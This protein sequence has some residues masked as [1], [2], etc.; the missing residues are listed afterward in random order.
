M[1]NTN[2]SVQEVDPA[3]ASD[4][5]LREFHGLQ[6]A[7]LAEAR[8]HDTPIPLDVLSAAIKALPDFIEVAVFLARDAS[9]GAVGYA[10]LT[11]R[12][13]GANPD[14]ADLKI[15]AAPAQRRR[16]AAGE[17]LDVVCAAAEKRSHRV[18][19]T[20]TTAGIGWGEEL[21]K[22]VGGHPALERRTWRLD[23]A[24]VD[25]DEIRLILAQAADRAR[26]YSLEEFAGELPDEI[27][28]DAVDLLQ[29]LN[30]EAE[31]EIHLE[32]ARVITV[33]IFRALEKTWAAMG[34]QRRWFFARHEASGTLAG[35]ADGVWQPKSPDTI[36]TDNTVVRPEF[37]GRSL[38]LWMKA[39][40]IDKMLDE[41]TEAREIHTTTTYP[42]AAMDSVDERVGFAPYVH[43][44]VWHLEVE[45]VQSWLRSSSQ[46]RTS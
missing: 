44:T 10:L 34:L 14:I 26:G 32:D 22:E 7:Q 27:V 46:E 9:R 36:V 45:A 24:D 29:F 11:H 23:V 39:C 25:R 6:M 33:P 43:N 21:C 28:D 20:S 38:G 16:G 18:L 1:D 37:R 42:N 4:E 13:T 31:G 40:M 5:A 12:R 30:T 19:R 17:L 15:W 2:I 3:S 41:W 35:V 8:P